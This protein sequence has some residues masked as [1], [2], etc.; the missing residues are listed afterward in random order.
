MQ[1]PVNTRKQYI[2]SFTLGGLKF[3][4]SQS[5][6]DN[7]DEGSATAILAMHPEMYG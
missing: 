2:P 4:F 7:G 5:E 6:S 1:R 3:K